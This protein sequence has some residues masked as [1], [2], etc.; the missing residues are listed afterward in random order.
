MVGIHPSLRCLITK[1]MQ[2]SCRWVVSLRSDGLLVK[3]PHAR[4]TMGTHGGEEEK[5]RQ[6][7]NRLLYH[8]KQR[9]WL[10]LDIILG[11]WAEKNLEHLSS[12]RLD[13]FEE[14]LGVENPDVFKCLTGQVEPDEELQRNPVF[15]MVRK[16]VE[17]RMK[18]H[19]AV[20]VSQQREWVRGWNDGQQS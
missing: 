5:R 12:E 4:R 20:G 18:E 13:D 1:Y 2:Q 17:E 7:L 14:L 10:E 16:T 6:R 11:Q 19:S 9:G 8:A 3:N 15:E